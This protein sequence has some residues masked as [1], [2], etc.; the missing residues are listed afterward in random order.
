MEKH[1]DT[2]TRG[3]ARLVAGGGRGAGSHEVALLAAVAAALG[4]LGQRAVADQV[5][6]LVAVEAARHAGGAGGAGSAELTLGT[7][8]ARRA[9]GGRSGLTLGAGR[10]A[11][12]V[13]ALHYT[14]HSEGK[15]V[16][17][18]CI[19]FFSFFFS[20]I[21]NYKMCFMQSRQSCEGLTGA[22][23]RARDVLSLEALGALLG[24]ELDRLAVVQA[25]EAVSRDGRLQNKQ[26]KKKDAFPFFV[27]KQDKQKS[28]NR[29][30]AYLVD[31]DVLTSGVGDEAKALGG[32][33]PLD[34]AGLTS[35]VVEMPASR[36]ENRK[37]ETVA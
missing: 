35:C 31:K 33:E 26:T 14:Q 4:L 32:V 9:R 7:R 30:D 10:T 19:T 15:N 23:G 11:A 6:L 24:A 34:G 18:H 28:S 1:G 2:G 36:G 37:K 5:T 3:A 12:A 16:S 17:L 8:R 22:A 27:S 29:D 21:M 13:A 20:P 25:A